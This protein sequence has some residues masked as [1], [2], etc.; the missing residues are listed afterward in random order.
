MKG[1]TTYSWILD[2]GGA[3]RGAWQSGVIHQFMRWTRE[4]G[5][6]TQVSMGASA[7]GYAAPDVDMG[8]GATVMRGGLLSSPGSMVVVR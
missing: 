2:S 8:T 4:D 6:Y 5:C 7:G 1:R 3:G